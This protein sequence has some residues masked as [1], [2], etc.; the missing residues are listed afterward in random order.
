[1][2]L[3][4]NNNGGIIMSKLVKKKSKFN[5]APMKDVLSGTVDLS[6]PSLK[7][8]DADQ[9]R[10]IEELTKSLVIKQYSYDKP[11]F[12]LVGS[13]E[14]MVWYVDEETG[15]IYRLDRED[16]AGFAISTTK[17]FKFEKPLKEELQK[18]SGPVIESATD[19]TK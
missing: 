16:E 2:F 3:L 9:L 4:C 15:F 17:K 13:I 19:N 8:A 10:K 1:M 7:K 14:E 5:V 6:R 18:L 11:R 12:Q